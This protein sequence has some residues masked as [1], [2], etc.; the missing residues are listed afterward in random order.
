M[1]VLDVR[2]EGEY[3]QGHIPGAFNFPLLNNEERHQVGICYKEQGPSAA[4]QL[5]FRL[6]GPKFADYLECLETTFPTKQVLLYCWRGGMRS[7]IMAWLLSTAGWDAT[8]WIGGYKAWRAHCGSIFESCPPFVVIA[9]KTGCGKTELLESLENAGEPIVHFEKLAQ[10]RGSA[11]GGLG[12]PI[13]PTQEQ[14]ENALSDALSN[15][16]SSGFAWV[17]DESRA[18]GRLRIP[19][20][21]YDKVQ[22]GRKIEVE[23]P[24]ESRFTRIQND[25]SVFSNAELAEK[26]LLLKKRMGYDVNN[27]A[28]KALIEQNDRSL[29]LNAVLEYYDK[30]YTH[31]SRMNLASEPELKLFWNTEPTEEMINILLE[32]KKRH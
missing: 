17:E 12:L 1:A 4:V 5:G 10:H 13:Q 9:G 30:A 8:V 22:R 15:A 32:W 3:A 31:S 16:R 25:H 21:V 23:R 20:E 11:F 24:F 18:I 19:D 7:N 6:V 2:S 26:T 27:R 29:W 14:F 28:V